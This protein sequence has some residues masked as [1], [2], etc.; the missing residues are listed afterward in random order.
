MGAV[1]PAMVDTN[2]IG[3]GARKLSQSGHLSNGVSARRRIVTHH[4]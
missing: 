3:A 2:I 1:I 4:R